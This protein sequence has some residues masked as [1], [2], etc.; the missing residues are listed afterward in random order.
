MRESKKNQTEGEPAS[1]APSI[2]ALASRRPSQ[3]DVWDLLWAFAW[4][5][6]LYGL[7]YPTLFMSPSG[8]VLQ[9]W[10]AASECQQWSNKHKQANPRLNNETTTNKHN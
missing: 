4:R 5:W 3:Q 1:F 7:C 9:R 2:I 10:Q 6:G 8:P